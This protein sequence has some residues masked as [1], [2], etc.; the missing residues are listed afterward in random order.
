V[1]SARKVPRVL[2]AA[3]RRKSTEGSRVPSF[4]S[5][6]GRKAVHAKWTGASGILTNEVTEKFQRGVGPLGA[7]PW[8]VGLSRTLINDLAVE[9]GHRYFGLADALRWQTED[10]LREDNDV[11]QHVSRE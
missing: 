1:Q 6:Q 2:Q 4:E 10:V 11:G 9:N 3:R 5:Y 8:L 7:A